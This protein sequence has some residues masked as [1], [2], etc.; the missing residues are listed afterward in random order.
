MS[1]TNTRFRAI[2]LWLLCTAVLPLLWIM[3][4]L[5]GLFG[6]PERSINM[7]L[8]QDQCGNALFGGDPGQ[9]ISERTGLAAMEGKR[10]AKI[11][12]PCIDFF[13]GQNHC[14]DSALAWQMKLRG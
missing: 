13:F 12:A 2:I 11:T 6:S 9:S 14:Y 4:G 7:A 1:D 3:Q 10:W 5:Q 8:A